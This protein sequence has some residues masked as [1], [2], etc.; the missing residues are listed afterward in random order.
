MENRSSG[1][2]ALNII[3]ECTN[4]NK[5]R[6]W[7]REVYHES[8]KS[9]CSWLENRIGRIR[10]ACL[11]NIC[12]IVWDV[13]EDGSRRPVFLLSESLIKRYKLKCPILRPH[14]RKTLTPAED[15]SFSAVAL[16][17]S[18]SLTKEMVIATCLQIQHKIEQFLDQMIDFELKF[19]F[20]TLYHS[21]RTIRF[22]FDTNRLVKV[23]YRSFHENFRFCRFCLRLFILLRQMS[24]EISTICLD[25]I[26]LCHHLYLPALRK[27]RLRGRS[28][29]ICSVA[30]MRSI[31]MKVM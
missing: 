19:P 31:L 10:G 4:E 16:K 9:I 12:S 1:T 26:L 24:I 28:K 15:I 22:I 13:R 20:G 18:V 5:L 21:R 14:Q 17:F 25:C 2:S 11:P 29:K 27:K 23:W 6:R 7:K 30:M 8:W 3:E